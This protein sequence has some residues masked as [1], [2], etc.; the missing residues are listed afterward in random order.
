MSER[1]RMELLDGV[2]EWVAVVVVA[3]IIIGTI[4]GVFV[5]DFRRK[6]DK[7]DDS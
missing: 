5:A 4:V 6:K 1:R 3:V 7:E 2:P